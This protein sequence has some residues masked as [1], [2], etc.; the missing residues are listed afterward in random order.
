[1]HVE[2]L[3]HTRRNPALTREQVAGMSDLATIFD[4]QGS[5]PENLV[6]YAGRVCYKSTHRMGT[7]PEF[8]S[9]RVR[10]GHEDIIEHVVVTV[11]IRS[12][13]EP[14]HWRTINRHCEVSDLGSHEWIVSG[15]TRVWLDLF[16]R[17]IALEAVPILKAVAPAVFSELPDGDASQQAMIAELRTKLAETA[18]AAPIFDLQSLLPSHT[19]PMRVTLLGFTQPV[20]DDPELLLHHGSATFFFEGI[21]RACT[22]QLVRHRLASFSQESQRYCKYDVLDGD[23]ELPVPALPKAKATNGQAMAAHFSPEQEQFIANVYARGFSCEALGEAYDAH[24]ATIRS[25]VLRCGGQLRAHE[26]SAPFFAEIDTPLKARVLGLIFADGAA[27]A[28]E[29][30]PLQTSITQHTDYKEWL[31]RLGKLWGGHLVPGARESTVRLTIPGKQ[32]VTMLTRLGSAPGK[33]LAANPPGLPEQLVPA[34]LL[35]YLEG[36]GHIGRHPDNPAITFTGTQEMVAWIRTQLHRALQV[37]AEDPVRQP[38]EACYQLTFG[39][40]QVPRILEWLY[41][42]APFYYAHPARAARAIAWSP[43]LAD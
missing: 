18:A 26:N 24:P 11:R 33:N 29:G 5:Y 13:Q 2:L 6:E 1:M 22:H 15:N 4:G 30:E 8:I 42:D 38:L 25:I 10:E 19:G 43:R 27:L 9:A 41:Q 21:S 7:A 20:L 35:G 37:E 32:L 36:D 31:E 17:G 16:R 40:D 23:L 14:L 28:A 34:F 12:S 39:G 3:A